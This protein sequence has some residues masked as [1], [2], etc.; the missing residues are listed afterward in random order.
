MGLLFIGVSYTP[1]FKMQVAPVDCELLEHDTDP[2]ILPPKKIEG[3]CDSVASGQKL[4][5]SKRTGTYHPLNT[6]NLN[7][8]D[9]KFWDRLDS[10]HFCNQAYFTPGNVI[11]M[12]QGGV[13]LQLRKESRGD[14]NFT[15]G[16]LATKD[17]ADAKYL[18]GRFEVVMKPVKASGTIT[19]FFLYRFDPWQEIDLEF[20]GRDTSHIL[21]NVFYNPGD[22]GDLYNYGYRGTPVLVDL[23]FDASESFH[24]FAI[25]WDAEEIR[26]FA[27]ERLIHR[28]SAGSPTP[29]PHLPMRFYMNVW[30][31]CSTELAGPFFPTDQPLEAEFKAVSIYEWKPSN[32]PWLSSFLDKLFPFSGTKENWRQK[33]EWI[34]PSR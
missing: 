12:D 29:I 32:L 24:K 14:R 7:P 8:V 17:K 13:K 22:A 2:W 27:D 9:L 5:W 19:A 26:W 31:T 16:S 11:P 28:R 10:T 25:E 1:S 33:A 21:L 3:Y 30:P 15:S 6:N 4:G 34:Q 23:G 18:Y 20:L